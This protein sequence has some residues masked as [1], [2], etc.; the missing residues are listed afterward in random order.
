MITLQFYEDSKDARIF[1]KKDYVA[2]LNRNVEGREDLTLD[3]IDE[4]L[5]LLNIERTEW[6]EAGWGWTCRLNYE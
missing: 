1:N 6:K 3:R 2:D 5:E 4:I